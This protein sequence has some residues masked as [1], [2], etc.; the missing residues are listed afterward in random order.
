MTKIK[1]CGLTRPGDI[2]AANELKPEFVGF[3]FAAK[4]RRYVSSERAKR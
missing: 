2:A 4:S 3:V 1:L